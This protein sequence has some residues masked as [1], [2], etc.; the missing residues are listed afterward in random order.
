M[1]VEFQDYYQTLGVDRSASPDDIKRAYRQLARKHHPD[2]SMNDPE[3][4]KKFARISE[5]YEVLSDA[6][7]RRKYDQLGPNWRAGQRFDPHDF[8]F[9]PG[10]GPGNAPGS[11]PGRGGRG[12]FTFTGSGGDF[13][14]FFESLFGA[15]HGRSG[16]SSHARFDDLFDPPRQASQ[17]R[18][19]HALTITLDEAR[20]GST[21]PLTVQQPD[22]STQRIE[23][24]I[25]KGVK[26]GSKLRLRE[27]GLVLRIDF[28][29]HPL[30]TVDRYDL[31]QEVKVT[32]AQAALGTSID[33]TTL[34]GAA[35][36]TLPP[37]TA[38]GSKLRM[39]GQGMPKGANTPERGDLFVRIHITVPKNL[40]DEQRKLYEQ[41]RELD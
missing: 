12:G 20:Q 26:P 24:R 7:K 22:G 2:V 38:S 28:A 39:K 21:R 6:E 35:S 36:L 14:E 9:T 5:A 17:S 32:P 11:A 34:D 13:S 15:M 23:V 33:V 4:A 25:P 37:G 8:G 41:L 40:T 10:G 31:I 3:A 30:F 18:R 19:E 16:R 27:H 29:P 1:A